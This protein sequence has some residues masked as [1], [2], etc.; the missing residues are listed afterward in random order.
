MG[1]L[2]MLYVSTKPLGFRSGNRFG[3]DSRKFDSARTIVRVSAPV[4]TTV[5]KLPVRSPNRPVAFILIIPLLWG[6][7]L[8]A[9][10]QPSEDKCEKK[11][12]S[13]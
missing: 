11:R 9:L 8:A 2:L 3:S 7:S 12:G 1:V 6:K 10:S 5:R 13:Y 4:T